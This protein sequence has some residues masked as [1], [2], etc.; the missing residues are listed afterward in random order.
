MQL[1]LLSQFIN[2]YVFFPL[3][4]LSCLATC[5]ALGF[6]NFK[7]FDGKKY[8]AFPIPCAYTL[9]RDC[10][11]VSSQYSIRVKNEDCNK[12]MHSQYCTKQTLIL[13][14]NGKL[15]EI[16][17]TVAGDPET[18]TTKLQINGEANLNGYTDY[19][20][21][22]ERLS[23]NNLFLST[24]Q[25]A[26]STIGMNFFL[27]VDESLADKTCGL[28]G[29]YNK[30]SSDDFMDRNNGI[31]GN[32]AFFLKDW[33]LQN[34][35]SCSDDSVK[36]G[37]DEIPD[38]IY[39]PTSYC[40]L[41]SQNEPQAK[42]R[43]EVISNPDG[44]FKECLTIEPPEPFVARAMKSGCRQSSSLCAVA[45]GYAKACGDKGGKVGDWRDAIPGCNK[46]KYNTELGGVFMIPV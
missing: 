28:C 37:I 6:T 31:A 26:I 25:F 34:Q 1:P 2:K 9:L 5:S 15:I 40:K 30:K 45:A 39:S 8:E 32:A 7:T 10:S 3:S 27:T 24:S 42:K 21:R 12:N 38:S 23:D 29:R 4:S 17:R 46:R 16:Q 43:A 19:A 36:L 44:P 14:W 33:L 20:I 41:Y 13:T 18:V 22:V 35:P 11:T